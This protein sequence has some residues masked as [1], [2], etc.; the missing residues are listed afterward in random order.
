MGIPA[1]HITRDRLYSVTRTDSALKGAFSV[2][3]VNALKKNLFL[4]TKVVVI[5][6]HEIFLVNANIFSY[7][8]TVRLS[9]E[10]KGEE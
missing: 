2:I 4:I 7:K 5:W 10:G 9:I 6:V 8:C 3:F 1:Y